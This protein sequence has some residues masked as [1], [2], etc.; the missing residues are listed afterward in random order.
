MA[1]GWKACNQCSQPCF[2]TGRINQEMDIIDDIDQFFAWEMISDKGCHL[3]DRCARR[4]AGVYYVRYEG[5]Y[6]G[7]G[8]LEQNRKIMILLFKRL[9]YDSEPRPA[10]KL[11]NQR[12]LSI[13]GRCGDQRE[14]VRSGFVE[15]VQ[16]P[17]SFKARWLEKSRGCHQKIE[18]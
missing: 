5:R 8:M 4:R 13:A 7:A 1:V 14:F 9:P 6:S 11:R 15:L 18:P 16:E 3:A 17:C 12:G 2:R 10:S